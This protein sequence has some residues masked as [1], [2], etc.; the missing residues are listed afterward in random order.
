M[1]CFRMLSHRPETSVN[2]RR[3]EQCGNRAPE[4]NLEAHILC[5]RW[6]TE[7]PESVD[8]VI[9]LNCSRKMI[10]GYS[11]PGREWLPSYCDKFDGTSDMNAATQ[12]PG[13]DFGASYAKIFRIH[14]TEK[15]KSIATH[16][17]QPERIV[18]W[19][20]ILLTVKFPKQPNCCDGRHNR[21]RRC[22]ISS[23]EDVL[24]GVDLDSQKSLNKSQSVS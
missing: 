22:P 16:C 3:T 19:Q 23:P 18:P 21:E 14:G 7:Y 10:R 4:S 12:R 8:S 5:L 15:Y 2:K 17:L 9:F 13:T 6:F 1:G 20:Q 24:K 11:E